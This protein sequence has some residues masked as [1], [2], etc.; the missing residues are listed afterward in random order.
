[1]FGKL[2]S[3]QEKTFMKKLM[4]PVGF[5]VCLVASVSVLAAEPS[6]TP[7]P[8]GG[9]NVRAKMETPPRAK[10]VGVQNQDPTRNG[11]VNT[12]TALSPLNVD[13]MGVGVQFDLNPPKKTGPKKPP[14]N[15]N[16]EQAAGDE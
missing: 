15:S 10:A 5:L 7:A 13:S 6:P 2:G 1:V 3:Q 4:V 11:Q 9:K 16:E 14:K 8:H 12:S